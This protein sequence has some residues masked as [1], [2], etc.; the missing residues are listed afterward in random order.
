MFVELRDISNL[1]GS[2]RFGRHIIVSLEQGSKLILVDFAV[3]VFDHLLQ[4]ISFFFLFDFF[5]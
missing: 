4:Q 5:F 3:L 2:F 1:H